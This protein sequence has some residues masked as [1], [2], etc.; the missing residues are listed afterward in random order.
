VTAGGIRET[1]T[2]E[3]V[4]DAALT[5]FAERG[6]HGTALSQIAETLRVRTPSLYNHM[7]AKHDLLLTIVEGTV[8]AVLE[9]FHRATAGRTDPVD[10]LYRAT[11]VYARRHATHRREAIV[12][13]RDTTSLNEPHRT[14]MQEHRR[15]HEHALRTIITEGVDAGRF[16]I[17]SPA[18]GSFAIREMCVSIA[19]WFRDD[20]PIG[21]DRVAR[22]Y[23][24]F[25]LNIVGVSLA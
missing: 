17:A 4:L 10:R 23:T 13:N 2:S 8:T 9:D 25:A 22:E 3:A 1:V 16:H 18:L 6:Y 19:R 12:V 21:P 15:A 5:L 20:G 14:R 11:L 7:R 24:E